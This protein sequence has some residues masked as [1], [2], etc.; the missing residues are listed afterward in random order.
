MSIL[1]FFF[2]AFRSV[3]KKVKKMI[4]NCIF[5]KGFDLGRVLF[6]TKK[7][8]VKAKHPII[9]PSLGGSMPEA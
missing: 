7:Y 9:C 5:K 2:G 1:N 3:F 6:L 4:F 8:S